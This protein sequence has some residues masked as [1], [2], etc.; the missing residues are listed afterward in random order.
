[1]TL[2]VK[3]RAWHATTSNT[4]SVG[5]EI[6][7]VGAYGINEKNPLD[8]WYASD[9][10]GRTRITIPKILGD[11]GVRMPGF[12]GH[13]AQSHVIRGMIQH[14]DLVQYDLDRKSTRL[15]SSH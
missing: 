5:I 4:R 6:A 13:P 14:Q 1:Q 2:D 8:E 10:D 15:N 3:E 9:P 12:V 7:N 11:G